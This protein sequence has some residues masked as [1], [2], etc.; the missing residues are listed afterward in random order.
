MKQ[1]IKKIFGNLSSFLLILAFLST[2]SVLITL[3]YNISFKKLDNLKN[4]KHIISTL[5]NLKK[6]DIEL[7]LIQFN[8]KSIQL[9]NEIDKLRKLYKYDFTGNYIINNTQEYLADLDKLSMLTRHFNDVAKLYYTDEYKKNKRDERVKKHELNKAFYDINSH[10]D[11]ILIKDS[12]YEEIKFKIVETLALVSFFVIIIAVFWYRRKLGLV[13][14]DILYLYAIDK[15][16][17][18]YEIFSEEADAIALKMKRRTPASKNPAMIDPLTEVSNIKGMISSY[19]EKKNMK[20][21]NLTCV[22]VFE[23]DNFSKTHRAFPQDFTQA[24]LKKIAFTMTL[25]QQSTDVVA[26]TEYNQFTVILSRP[27]KEQLFKDVDMIRETIS[28]LKFISKERQKV[29]ITVSGGF[30]IKPNNSSLDDAIKK[31]KENLVYAQQSGGNKVAQSS[32]V[33]ENKQ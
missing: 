1:S 24:V 7:A 32:E 22:A 33:A 16:K 9:L 11:S 17:K 20:E 2:L 26:R 13:Y 30:I 10:I 15:N 27:T 25:N 6:D 29:V 31:A 5:T 18:D 23:V 14:K 8:G 28:E 19:A 21:S 3:E 4:Q 12:T